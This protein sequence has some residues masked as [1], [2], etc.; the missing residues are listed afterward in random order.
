MWSRIELSNM[1]I[2]LSE[3]SNP[4]HMIFALTNSKHGSAEDIKKHFKNS[5]LRKSFVDC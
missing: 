1:W 2:P 3:S 4:E 5:E